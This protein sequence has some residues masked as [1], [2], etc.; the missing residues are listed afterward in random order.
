MIEHDVNRLLSVNLLEQIPTEYEIFSGYLHKSVAR[1]FDLR[2]K[3]A[4]QVSLL[5]FSLAEHQFR[6]VKVAYLC[7]KL[8]TVAGKIPF[9]LRGNL[10]CQLFFFVSIELKP[11][12]I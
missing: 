11:S 12:C 10:V 6:A 9:S 5:C 7:G 3:V 8:L 1:D 2:E 4:E